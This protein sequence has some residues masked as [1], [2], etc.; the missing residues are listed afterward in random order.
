MNRRCLRL[1]TALKTNDS[2]WNY[3]IVG[4]NKQKEVFSPF[5][6]NLIALWNSLPQD[7]VDAKHIKG[8]KSQLNS[9]TGPSVAIKHDDDGDA[10]SGWWVPKP[11]EALSQEELLCACPVYSPQ[12]PQPAMVRP[13][14]RFGVCSPQLL[15]RRSWCGHSQVSAHASCSLEVGMPP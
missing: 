14:P 4:L 1:L 8:V 6:Y 3:R 13:A 5:P 15:K 12:Y 9:W 2:K 7:V 10:A 11:Q